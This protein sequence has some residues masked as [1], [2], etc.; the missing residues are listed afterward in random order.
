MSAVEFECPTA[1]SHRALPERYYLQC[2]AM[3]EG[4]DIDNMLYICWRPDI[5]TVFEVAT[6]RDTQTLKKVVHLAK[7]IYVNDRPKRPTKLD[8]VSKCVQAKFVGEFCI[9]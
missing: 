3:M 1:I 8:I 9:I 4:L 6:C 5:T 2:L 7:S